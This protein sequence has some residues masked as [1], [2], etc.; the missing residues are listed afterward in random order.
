MARKTTA[1]KTAEDVSKLKS[2]FHTFK[3]NTELKFGGVMDA[4]NHIRP[5]VEQ[6]F[7]HL[8]EERAIERYRKTNGKV[9]WSPILRNVSIALVSFAAALL[10]LIQ[11]LDRQLQ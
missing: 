5:K 6:V 10:L 3:A 1:Q 8:I 7:E 2:D 4:L 9:N 11:I